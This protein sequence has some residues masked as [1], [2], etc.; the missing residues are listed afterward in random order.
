M[1]IN[2]KLSRLL[3]ENVKFLKIINIKIF[4]GF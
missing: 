2:Q 4:K 3:E 1:K